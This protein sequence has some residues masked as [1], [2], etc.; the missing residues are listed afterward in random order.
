MRGLGLRRSFVFCGKWE[1]DKKTL[2]RDA[3]TE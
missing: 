3:Y 1:D 2:Y